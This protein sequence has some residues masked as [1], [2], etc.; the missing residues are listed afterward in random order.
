VILGISFVLGA[1]AMRIWP[2]ESPGWKAFTAAFG[3]LPAIIPVV[4]TWL[5]TGSP[6]LGELSFTTA[7][8]W[9]IALTVVIPPVIFAVS[10]LIQLRLGAVA[11]K[12]GTRVAPLLPGLLLAAVV[13]VP[14]VAAEEIAWRGFLQGPLMADYGT[15][16]A[17]SSSA[18]RGASGMRPSLCA[19]TTCARPTGPRRSS[20]TR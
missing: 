7:D 11:V 4:Y 15:I 14:L 8:I 9:S 10:L 5:R 1:L 13:P 18:S 16:W 12:P 2:K 17:S 3:F 20:S 19:V 6:S